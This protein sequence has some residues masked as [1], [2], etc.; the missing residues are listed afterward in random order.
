MIEEARKKFGDRIEIKTFN[1]KYLPEDPED[2][3]E[4]KK[5]REKYR[6][7]GLPEIIING[8]K[9]AKKYK[10]ENLFSEICKYF[11]VRPIACL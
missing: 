5:L 7:I 8:K 3:P 4:I 2:P 9:F 11:L 10:S 1:V 6:V